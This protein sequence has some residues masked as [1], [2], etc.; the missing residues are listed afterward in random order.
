MLIYTDLHKGLKPWPRIL[1]L[2]GRVHLFHGQTLVDRTKPG[3]NAIKQIAEYNYSEKWYIL[4]RRVNFQI[5]IAI[6]ILS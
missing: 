4:L 1:P 3:P 5:P 2:M 6:E